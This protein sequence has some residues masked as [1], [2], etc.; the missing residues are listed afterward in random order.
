MPK[1]KKKK[2]ETKTVPEFAKLS[3]EIE[4]IRIALH[5]LCS[6]LTAVSTQLIILTEHDDI[7]F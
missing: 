2:P 4:D 6:R 7:P 1:L 3:Q 5:N